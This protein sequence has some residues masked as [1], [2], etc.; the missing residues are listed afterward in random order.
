MTLCGILNK[1]H[2]S[3]LC[4]SSLELTCTSCCK[5]CQN[6]GFPR[7]MKTALPLMFSLNVE[8]T[9][10]Q[11]S[12]QIMT[13]CGILNKLHFSALYFVFKWCQ[14]LGFQRYLKTALVLMFS[15]NVELTA[16]QRSSQIITLCAILNKLHFSTLCFSCL[17]R[18]CTSCCKWCQNL[19]FQRQLKTALALMFLLNV[20]L[21][22]FQRSSQIITLC[23]ILNKVHFSALCFSYLQRACTS[24]CKWCQNL[25]FQRQLKTAMALMFSL[26]V[27][28]T[29]FQRS[30]QIITLSGIL[31]KLHFST[32]CFIDSV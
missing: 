31:K 3:A 9:A 11:R 10:F 22:A 30:S 1:L 13:L 25:A 27:D 24:C 32:L 19:G 4:F 15:L 28:L 29:A 21:S 18:T 12:S 23:G 14:N 5:W 6:L 20:E 26:N 16:F 8:L 2:F 17:Q 7:Q